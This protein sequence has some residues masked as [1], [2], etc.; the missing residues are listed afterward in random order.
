MSTPTLVSGRRMLKTADW[1]FSVEQEAQDNAA[2]IAHER[3]ERIEKTITRAALFEEVA[4]TFTEA[5][6]EAFMNALARG[7][8]ADVHTLYC[9]L[10][11]V[12]ERIVERRLAGGA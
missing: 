1:L 3:R 6:D 7:S 10:D 8:N 12:K 11:Q 2:L 9:L 5:Q 4:E